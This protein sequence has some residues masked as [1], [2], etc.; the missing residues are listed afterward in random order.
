MPS[1]NEVDALR[2]DVH[3]MNQPLRLVLVGFVAVGTLFDKL[4]RQLKDFPRRAIP[5]FLKSL[6]DTI[7]P[8]TWCTQAFSATGKRARDEL[9]EQLQPTLGEGAG[10]VAT[11][12]VGTRPPALVNA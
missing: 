4:S 9:A 10:P 1:Q 5:V 7:P 2:R 3:R 6:R 11:I 8:A 12:A